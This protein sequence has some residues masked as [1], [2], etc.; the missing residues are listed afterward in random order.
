MAQTRYGPV[1][2]SKPAEVTKL[3]LA[4]V[5]QAMVLPQIHY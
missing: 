3:S 4:I 2:R 1:G 5:S